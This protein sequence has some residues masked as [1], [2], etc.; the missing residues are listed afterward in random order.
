[1]PEPV[2]GRA[3]LRILEAFICL[4]DRLEFGLCLGIALVAIGVPFHRQ[5]AIAGLE[6]AI[7]SIAADFEQF[8]IVEFG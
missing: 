8:V 5:L 3:L 4:A 2:I 1:M 7:V 6:H